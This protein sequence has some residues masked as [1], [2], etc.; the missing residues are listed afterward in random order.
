MVASLHPLGA[1]AVPSVYGWSTDA[2]LFKQA[3]E[4][5]HKQG[6]QGRDGIHQNTSYTTSYHLRGARNGRRLRIYG[7]TD[8]PPSLPLLPDTPFTRDYESSYRRHLNTITNFQLR[9]CNW[10]VARP[11]ILNTNHEC[12]AP[13][14][15]ASHLAAARLV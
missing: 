14:S 11:S 12:Y 10:L 13:K 1:V 2:D 9:N 3:W 5:V 15:A 6:V 7:F 8:V 4:T